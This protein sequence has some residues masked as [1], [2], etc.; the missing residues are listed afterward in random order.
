[1]RKQ[2]Q[3]DYDVWLMVILTIVFIVALFFIPGCG[4]KEDPVASVYD[5][6]MT[7]LEAYD[8]AVKLAGATGG[9]VSDIRG[10]G[11][12]MPILAGNCY[13]VSIPDWK[14]TDVG[15]IIIFR[16]GSK[17]VAHQVIARDGAYL[18]TK[19]YANESSDP[20]TVSEDDYIGTV[21]GWTIHREG[22]L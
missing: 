15:Q 19:G 5:S 10:T 8:A 17:Q 9:I 2:P 7:A 16:H 20:Y 21:I 3:Y 6:P 4:D 11:S 22:G 13:T 1:M 14:A 12:M 18:R